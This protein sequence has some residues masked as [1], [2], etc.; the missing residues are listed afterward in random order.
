MKHH[1]DWLVEQI[2]D[3]GGA[4]LWTS[5]SGRQYRVDPERRVPVFIPSGADAPAPF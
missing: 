2:E 1:G 5:P 3:S 4:M